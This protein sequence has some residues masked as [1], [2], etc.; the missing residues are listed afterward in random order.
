MDAL[1]TTRYTY[2]AVGQLL[3]EDGPFDSD[4]VTNS[5][6]IGMAGAGAAIGWLGTEAV[7]GLGDT[8]KLSF[9]AY[10]CGLRHV[11]TSPGHQE[12]PPPL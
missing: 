8:L 4:T 10:K 1:G 12:W 7:Y 3:T 6:S 9:C 11:D 2:D 5:Y